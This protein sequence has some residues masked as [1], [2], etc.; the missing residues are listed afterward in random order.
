MIRVFITLALLLFLMGCSGG[1]TEVTT[2]DYD[3]TIKSGWDAYNQNNFSGAQQEFARAILKDTTRPEGYIGSG[4]AQFRLQKPFD[5]IVYFRDAFDYITTVNDSVDAL[6]GYSGAYL[7]T[8]EN[9]N[10]I[11]LFKRYT[12]STY[13]DAFPFRKHDYTISAGDLEA[14]QAMA[15]YRLGMYSPAEQPDPNNAVYHLNQALYSPF[16]YTN[17][18]DLMGEITDYLGQS[19]GGYF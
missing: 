8:G 2:D 18:Q 15:F 12:I 7:A 4:W 19:G 5:A 10:V 17:Q 13:D 9:T 1:I 16:V 3:N 14:V 6:C 11:N